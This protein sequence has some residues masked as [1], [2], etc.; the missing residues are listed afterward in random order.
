MNLVIYH[1]NLIM[2]L[3]GKTALITGATDGLGKLL[4]INLGKLGCNLIIHGR[5]KQKLDNLQENLIKTNS[6]ISV[7]QVL[8]DFNSPDTIETTFAK[9]TNLDILINNAGVFTEGDTID[10]SSK[11]IIELVNVNL[12]SCLLVTKTLLPIL[13]QSDYAQILNV[14]SIAG[15]E[16]PQEY[17]HT[18]Y[19]ATKFGVQAFTEAL[20]KEYY[21]SNIRV[22]GYYPG[23]MNTDLFKKAGLDY[24]KNEPWMFD[25]QESVEAI[26]FMLT[27]DKRI[28]IKRMDLI[29][30]IE[31]ANI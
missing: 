15:V 17:F 5:N 12:L 28:N 7:T 9:I 20:A 2:N 31:N 22:M 10:V 23:G 25:V 4:A 27:R 14:S 8:C 26:I 16:I 6:N 18:I 11:R 30:Q 13:R 29:N 1:V 24:Q 21:N 19:S 3:K